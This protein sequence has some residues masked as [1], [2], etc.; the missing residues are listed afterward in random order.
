LL[1]EGTANVTSVS[2]DVE[3]GVAPGTNVDVDA[4]SASGHLSSEMPLSEA[5]GAEPGPTL[6]VRGKTVSGDVRLVR[7][8]L[9]A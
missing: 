7:A 8:E 6:V 3:L 5:P 9:G 1:R 4:T 2:G